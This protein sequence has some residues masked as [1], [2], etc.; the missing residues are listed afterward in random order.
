MEL[1]KRL[2]EYRARLGMTQDDLAERLYV[3]RQTV[4]SWEN[5]KSYPDIH[6]LLMLSGLFSVSLDTLVKGDIETMKETIN[7]ESIHIFKRYNR[8]FA[9]LLIVCIVS[10]LPLYRWAGIPGIILWALLFAVTLYFGWRLEKIKKDNDIHTYREIVA[11]T[12]GEKLDEIEKAREQ[13]KRR[14]QQ[15]AFMAGSAAVGVFI[16]WVISLVIRLF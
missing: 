9:I 5:D 3:S 16:A 7:R 6:S 8:L 4:S 13:G 1:G 15:F 2:K 12:N 14:Y 11:F 10:L